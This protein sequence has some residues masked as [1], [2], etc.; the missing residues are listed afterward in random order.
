MPSLSWILREETD[1]A[2]GNRQPPDPSRHS[3]DR[4]LQRDTHLAL[5]LS[6]VSEDSTSSVM[7][8]PVRLWAGDKEG[9]E[10]KVQVSAPPLWG[11]DPGR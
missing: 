4:R 8:L 11:S 5:T 3:T 6:I 10:G 2:I 1:D 7:V 9:E